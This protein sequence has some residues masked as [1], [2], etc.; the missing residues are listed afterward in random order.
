MSA[1]AEVDPEE[2]PQFIDDEEQSKP[3][4]CPK[5]RGVAPIWMTTF[6][7]MATLLMALFALM[8]NFAEM[9]QRQKAQA[10]GSINA[11]FGSKVIIP[12]I[13]IPVAES[14][15]FSEEDDVN[16][17]LKTLSQEEL[18]ALQVEETYTSLMESLEGEIRKGE[19]VVRKANNK[20]VVELQSFSSKDDINDDY[21][22]MQSVIEIT[23]KVVSVQSK[24]PT[25]IEVR[26][27]DLAA[28][29][30]MRDRRIEDAKRKFDKLGLDLKDDI[31]EGKLKLVLQD[32]N[33]IIRLAGEGSF[34]SGSDQVRPA[35][36][37][38][39]GRIGSEIESSSGKIRIE[40]HTDNVKIAFSDR[41]RSNWDL[42]SARS[43]SVG[44]ILLRDVGIDL[45][46]LVVAGYADSRPI[47]SNDSAQG[48]AANRRIEI[49]VRGS[50][51]AISQ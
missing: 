40:G 31:E 24:T 51:E 46:R 16:K 8:Y 49:I 45:D 7:D 11:A 12:V 48:R 30:A 25:E 4:K 21:Y 34:V 9:D 15:I 44:G 39:L 22:L 33:L 23:E 20:V 29:Q 3:R 1:T 18:E 27:Q 47:E 37:E 36:R 43:S 2:I 42:S 13:D 19:V 5:C 35:F 32:D 26:K 6:A 41:F 28:L 38:L 50:S 10:L 17:N 14:T